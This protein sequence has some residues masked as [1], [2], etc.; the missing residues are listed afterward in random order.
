MKQNIHLLLQERYSLISRFSQFN[1]KFIVVL[2]IDFQKPFFPGR[3][4]DQDFDIFIF[5]QITIIKDIL[6]FL[7]V[8]DK[9]ENYGNFFYN[10]LIFVVWSII[11][12]VWNVLN[13]RWSEGWQL[14]I[15]SKHFFIR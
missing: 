3:L 6:N 4:A 14:E 9:G 13:G 2:F 5:H 15:S 10:D 8:Y 1:S 11:I 12:F 7:S